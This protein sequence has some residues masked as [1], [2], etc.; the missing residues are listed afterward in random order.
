MEFDGSKFVSAIFV[1]AVYDSKFELTHD[2][3]PKLSL[4]IEQFR[5]PCLDA[6]VFAT[7]KLDIKKNLSPN[8]SI[9]ANK[10]KPEQDFEATKI[11]LK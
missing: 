1:N 10:L 9:L 5:M 6:K 3:C 11:R 8:I 2:R 4:T 7:I